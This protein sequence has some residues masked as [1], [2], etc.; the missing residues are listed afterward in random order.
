MLC[1]TL[2]SACVI[3]EYSWLR[4][5]RPISNRGDSYETDVP[6]RQLRKPFVTSLWNISDCDVAVIN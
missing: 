1:G 2:Y 3:E 6:L 4:A 5:R